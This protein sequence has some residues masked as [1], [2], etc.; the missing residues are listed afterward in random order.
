MRQHHCNG[1]PLH[2]PPQLHMPQVLVEE[3][4]EDCSL[5][6]KQTGKPAGHAIPVTI[7]VEI[8]LDIRLF[9]KE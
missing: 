3:L 7:K 6:I 8:F 5:V 9:L 1:F 4:E 2:N